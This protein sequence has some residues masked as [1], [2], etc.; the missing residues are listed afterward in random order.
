[1]NAA[2]SQFMPRVS[3]PPGIE[4][5]EQPPPVGEQLLAFI[6]AP[7]GADRV[8]FDIIY[9]VEQA[10]DFGQLQLAVL[11][12]IRTDVEAKDPVV[13]G[14]FVMPGTF[15][16]ASL[17]GQVALIKGEL[18]LRMIGPSNNMGMGMGAGGLPQPLPGFAP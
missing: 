6:E 3:P 17:D 14:Q 1:M 2:F 11:V 16:A 7:D 10:G 18:V 15:D 4:F 5:K 13:R 8:H 9:K 12:E